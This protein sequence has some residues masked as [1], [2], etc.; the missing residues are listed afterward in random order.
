ML[1]LYPREWLQ[2]SPSDPTFKTTQ[3]CQRQTPRARCRYSD[4]VI[5]F[6]SNSSH[7]LWDQTLNEIFVLAL[8]F[9]LVKE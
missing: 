8:C 5:Q 3:D 2:D 6:S 7:S 4:D 9:E 1:V